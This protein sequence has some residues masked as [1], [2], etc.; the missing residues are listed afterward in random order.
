MERTQRCCL[1]PHPT[2]GLQILKDTQP[3]ISQYKP[4]RV[5]QDWWEPTVSKFSKP[6]DLEHLFLQKGPSQHQPQFLTEEIQSR[7]C[8]SHKSSGA[9][10]PRIPTLQT[11]G[12][13]V[14][15]LC[16]CKFNTGPKWNL[17]TA[18]PWTT[19]VW[20]AWIHLHADFSGAEY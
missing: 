17:Y 16:T 8:I 1:V 4:L 9:T 3:W 15:E 6:E 7:T 2:Y 13:T 10:H 19:G 14:K 11:P 20:T 18:D 5:C 12:K